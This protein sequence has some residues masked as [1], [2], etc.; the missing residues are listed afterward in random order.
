VSIEVQAL[1]PWSDEFCF[2]LP[3][4]DAQHRALFEIVGRLWTFLDADGPRD[5]LLGLVAE[6]EEYTLS[7]FRAEEAFMRETGYARYE[8]HKKAHDLFVALLAEEKRLILDGR[9]LSLRMLDFL[10]DWLVSHVLIVD[11]EYA[12]HAGYCRPKG[13]VLD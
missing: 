5:E 2:G 3:E 8:S 9:T 11:R 10:Q 7:H 13:D 4:I 1:I 6:L 12:A